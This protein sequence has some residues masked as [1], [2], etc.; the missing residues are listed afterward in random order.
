MPASTRIAR[1][2]LSSRP[3]RLAVERLMT[4]PPRALF[5]AWTEQFGLW[6]AAPATVLMVPEVDIPFFFETHY[7]HERH[8]HYGR[9]I[10]LAPD[11]RVELTWVTAAGTRGAETVVSV[12]LTPI[13]RGTRLHLTHAG[14]P[15]ALL[16]QRHEDA[17]PRVLENL[18]RVV[19][20][21]N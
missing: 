17:W 21:Q 19:S 9:F 20:A 10:T 13:G 8:P 16:Q 14:F 1:P 3:L 5:R 12:E 18:D 11:Q 15:D 4:A 6:F 7:N 2:D